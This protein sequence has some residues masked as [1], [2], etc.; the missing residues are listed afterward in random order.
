MQVLIKEKMLLKVIKYAPSLFIVFLSM[1]S[2][3]YIIVDYKSNL[4]QEYA[5]IEKDY[6]RI[7]KDKIK[8]NVET[9]NQYI[10]ATLKSSQKELEE[11]LHHAMDVVYEIALNIY[12]KKKDIA[13]KEEII[14]DIKNA[15]ETIRYENG[16]G[17]FS[18]HTIEGINVL[19]P[20]NRSLE[21]K[22]VLNR[23]DIYGDYPVKKAI[24]IAKQKGE[25]FFR[26]S[27]FKP[28]DRTKELKKFGIVK[29]FEPYNLI[30]TTALFD[31]D[32]QSKIEKKIYSTLKNLEYEDNGYIFIINNQGKVILT[33]DN[34][35]ASAYETSILMKKIK[36]FVKSTEK[37]KFVDYNFHHYEN[38]MKKE[39][40]KTSFL[41]KSDSLD[42][43][44]GNGFDL[45]AMNL[46][47]EAKY[48]TLNDEVTEY[49]YILIL[50]TIMIT[51]LLL[52]I[53]FYISSIVKRMFYTYKKQLLQ[54]EVEKTNNYF[55]TIVSM[56]DLIE[57]RDLYTAGHSRRVAQ[58]SVAIAKAMDFSSEEIQLLEQIGLLHDIGKIAI[59]DSILLKPGR[60]TEEEFHII[61]SH[62][63]VGYDVI[64]QIPM[65]KKF[66]NIILSHHERY[67]GSGYPNGLKGTEIP[68]LASVLSIADSFDAMTS[69]R[70]YN[71]TKTVKEALEELYKGRGVLYDPKVVSIAIEVLKD[72]DIETSLQVKQLPS[73]PIEKERFSYFFKDSL[74][75]FSNENYLD[76][77]LK[78]D[79]HQFKCANL[80]LVH[81]FSSFN[82]K[83]GWKAGNKL[84]VKIAK[85]I[86]ESYIAE[87]ICRFHGPNFVLLNSYHV[88]LDLDILNKKL[89]TD[90]V[91]CEV[92][93]FDMDTF[94]DIDMLQESLNK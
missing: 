21:G 23:Q 61:K 11:E 8:S 94:E 37:S 32:F 46:L 19:H 9:V 40:S 14:N 31:E 51:I 50:S 92:H 47:I 83:Y 39:Y 4:K 59:P 66:A 60:L 64:V 67:D 73:T 17:Y 45:D 52:L 84:L 69:T 54:K 5:S 65:F 75:N 34:I 58:Y 22:S 68:L 74:T 6:L 72:V 16:M 56:V 91:H 35:P 10:N 26:W 24:D 28:N 33:K 13:S 15:I 85:I 57:K 27:Y 12:E 36:N 18:I 70:I 55:Q 80:I 76:L 7:N 87:N 78:Q 44:I 43:V 41:Q 89:D 2:A 90:E 81:N 29:L 77:L 93:H 30:I 49:F 86:E 3:S 48:E 1:I 82:E 88:D 53:S 38:D 79:L 71:K 25:G 63:S 42:W 62:A 20:I